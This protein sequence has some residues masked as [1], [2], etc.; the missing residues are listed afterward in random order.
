MPIAVIENLE[1]IDVQHRH[2]QWLLL[3]QGAHPFMWADFIKATPVG[4]PG[5]FVRG[6]QARQFQIGLLQLCLHVL[7]LGKRLQLMLARTE[8]QVASQY[9]HGHQYAGNKP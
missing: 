4:Q 9:D 2:R 6:R 7:Q 8:D 5:Q 3:A 1:E